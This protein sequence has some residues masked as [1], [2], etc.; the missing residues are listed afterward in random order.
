MDRLRASLIEA[1]KKEEK[2]IIDNPLQAAIGLMT[3]N[4]DDVAVWTKVFE[5]IHE[6]KVIHNICI[7]VL[8]L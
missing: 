8:I 6:K 3:M 5:K 2:A 4:A 1:Q 7:Y